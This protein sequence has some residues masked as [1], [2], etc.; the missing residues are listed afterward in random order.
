MNILKLS[1][2]NLLHK[3]MRLTLSLI[4]FALGVGL[5]SF[6]ILMDKQL[7]DNFEK[8]LAEVDLVIG[9]KG[10]PLQMIL[11]AMYHVDAPT[12]NISIGD[13]RPF[14]NPKH[15]L[16]KDALPLSL[17]DSYKGFRIA[18][19]TTKILEWYNGQIDQGEVWGKDFEVALGAKV[20]ADLGINIGDTFKSSHGLNDD[21]GLEHDDVQSFIV[22]GILQP[23]GSVLDQLILT[24]NRTFW[25]V[26]DHEDHLDIQ[27]TSDN[28][29][30]EH[31]HDHHEEHNHDHHD[32]E[33]DV[34]HNHDEPFDLRASADDK[35]ITNLLI[36]F[37][38]R[39]FQALNMQRS[40]NE[41]TNMQAATPAIE[42]NRLFS[43]MD[44]AERALRL[45]AIV[46]II[47]SALSVFIS[48][49]SSLNERQY[50][51]A[52][53]R[54][55][56]AS[57]MKIFGLITLEGLIIAIIGAIIGL[58][59]SHFSMGYF[60]SFLDD[61]YRYEFSGWQFLT[62]EFYLFLTALAIGIISALI[63]AYQA[64]NKDI[65]DTITKG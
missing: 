37:R 36:R 3:P 61:T 49:Y 23:T 14:L 52:L 25:R 6:L 35:E 28:H 33:H 58:F 41:N 2:K 26:H 10:S 21:E 55:M 30:D 27:D 50:E 45:L 40:I 60:S 31:N 9:A 65:A 46:I 32:H 22:K 29:Q 39:N 42:I 43:M 18:G 7:Q 15:P 34:H 64:A 11:S 4:L 53:M 13:I 16:I 44:S 24:T 17:G 19:T 38:G 12:G 47:V 56:G 8:N 1:W 51:L 59:L 20:A 57:R 62:A 5:I 48:L 54:S 63:P